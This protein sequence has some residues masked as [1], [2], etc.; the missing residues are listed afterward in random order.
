MRPMAYVIKLSM[1]KSD[2]IYQNIFAVMFFTK[3]FYS[4]NTKKDYMQY[5]NA[6]LE[7]LLE[8]CI[9]C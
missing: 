8:S 7:C 6:L 4:F 5:S 2:I 3:P 1:I 9:S